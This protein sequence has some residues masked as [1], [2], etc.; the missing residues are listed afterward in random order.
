MGLTFGNVVAFGQS[1]EV[2]VGVGE[3][4]LEEVVEVEVGLGGEAGLGEDELGVGWPCGLEGEM[5]GREG[6]ASERVLE[7]GALL[8]VILVPEHEQ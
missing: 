4:S 3:F 1:G 7:D 8:G 5:D 6:S 2:V